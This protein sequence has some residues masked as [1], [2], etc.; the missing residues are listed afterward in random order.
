MDLVISERGRA[1]QLI[2]PIDFLFFVND[3]V[4]LVISD[5]SYP[6]AKHS[7]GTER[8]A[9]DTTVQGSFVILRNRPAGLKTE[10]IRNPE[11]IA[12]KQQ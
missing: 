12:D 11:D 1:E 10:T 6:R 7:R 5:L 2:F 3:N 4:N 8:R 9:T